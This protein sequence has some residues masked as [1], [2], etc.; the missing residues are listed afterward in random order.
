MLEQFGNL[1]SAIGLLTDAL[2]MASD[3]KDQSTKKDFQ[4]KVVAFQFLLLELIETA[5]EIFKL[6]NE[7]KSADK[8]HETIK[9][10]QH[11]AYSQNHT[12]YKLIQLVE[13]REFQQIIDLLKPS[14]RAEVINQLHSKRSRIRLVLRV[15]DLEKKEL[16]E[17]YTE[18]YH[19]KG[20]GIIN[21]LKVCTEEIA[22]LIRENMKF[23]DLI[24]LNK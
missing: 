8:P 7:A 10:L 23:E 24:S 16:Q 13:D 6:I 21:E 1:L 18:Q 15:D 12:I 3:K 11:L 20:V 2:K 5:D 19:Q 9:G 14:L 17:L 4:R 22:T